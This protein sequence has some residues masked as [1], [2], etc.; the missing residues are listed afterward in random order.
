M[1]KWSKEF[2]ADTPKGRQ[3]KKGG[4]GVFAGST[5]YPKESVRLKDQS[6]LSLSSYASRMNIQPLKASDFNEKLR[7]R[8]I[9]KTVTTK[10]FVE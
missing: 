5:F 9:P 3:V 6:M 1:L 8:I 7:E 2:R 4:F 10:R